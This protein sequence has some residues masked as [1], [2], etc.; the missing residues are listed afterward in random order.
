M[1]IKQ[2]FFDEIL[3]EFGNCQE[4]IIFIKTNTYDEH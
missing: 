1:I 4:E 3:Y 2:L